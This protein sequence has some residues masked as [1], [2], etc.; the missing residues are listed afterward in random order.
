MRQSIIRIAPFF[1]LTLTAIRVLQA[2]PNCDAKQFKGSYTLL[3]SGDIPVS[4]IPPLN[5]PFG[6]VGLWAADGNGGL[7]VQTT[8]SY[9]GIIF[10]ETFD[11]TYGVTGECVVTMN[12]FV[13]LPDTP[14]GFLLPVTLQG[15]L[16]D[17]GRSVTA[18]LVSPQGTV[19]HGNLRRRDN[20]NCSSAGIAARL[21][22][23]AYVVELSGAII[24]QAPN[25][26]GPF[27]RV[28]S[29]S[30]DRNGGFTAN[31][32]AS[33]GGAI[34]PEGFAGTYSVDA[35][36]NITMN[37]SLGQS[38]TWQGPLTDDGS[39]AD[40]MVT[41]PPGAAVVGTLTRSRHD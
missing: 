5:G 21:V 14:P 12:V 23:G 20:D 2:D 33:Y 13:P 32:N 34:F 11:G 36:C 4:P 40:L 6:R 19:I 1:L 37:Y 35:S 10:P 41:S 29:V 18:M 15:V 17:G 24:N 27:T 28:G 8:A 39:G 16:S 25:F 7:H 31:T 38:F 26:A 30:F 9:N 3:A 22:S